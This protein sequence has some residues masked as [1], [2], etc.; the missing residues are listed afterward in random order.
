MKGME[1]QRLSCPPASVDEQP[2]QLAS[3]FQAIHTAP[4]LSVS[5]IILQPEQALSQTIYVKALTIPLFQPIQ[6][7]GLQ[8]SHKL[9]TGQTSINLDS[10]N[11]PLIL[12]PLLH[13]D[14][15]DHIQTG[16]QKQPETIKIVSGFPVLAQNY[17]PCSPLGSPGKCKNAGKY[18][19]KH[20]GRDCLKPSV[21][22]KHVRSHTGERPF[23]C[24]ICGIAFKTQSNL[25]KHRRTQTH[26]NNARLPSESDSS[27]PLGEH[28][29]GR[30]TIGSPHKTKPSDRNCDGTRTV[31]SHSASD[32]T[33]AVTSENESLDT[34]APEI[35]S[36]F[37]VSESQWTTVDNSCHGRV[38]QSVLEKEFMK[39]PATPLQKRKIQEQRCQ[40]AAKP[41][42][43][44]RQ[45]ATY[46]EKLWE[47][48]SPDYKLKKCESTDSGYMSRSDSVEQQ[49]L[50]PNCLHSLCEHS[51]ETESDTTITS[52]R[53]TAGNMAKA[54]STEKSTGG[55][56][57]EKKKLEEHIS[58]LI[59]QNKAVV[60]NTQLD[61]VRPRKTVLSKQGSIDLPMPYTYKDSFHFD[62]RPFDSSRKKL[63]QC[64]AKSIFTPIEKS[65][66][67][68]FHSV[69]T[70]FS[71]TI[72]YVPVSRSNSMPFIESTRRIQDQADIS[73]AP[74]LAKMSHDTSSAL[75]SSK[76]KS[77]SM[78]DFPSSHPRALVRQAAVDDLPPSNTTDPSSSEEVKGT[79]KSGL[80]GEGTSTKHKKPNQRKAKMFTQEKW[81]VYGD[82]TFKK[83]YQKMKSNQTTKKQK[84]N[85]ITDISSFHL[86]TK[87][88]GSHD[89][90]PKDVKGFKTEN[91]VCSSV[92]LSAK[93]N[94]EKLVSSS[95]TVS[96]KQ[97]TEELEGYCITS[98]PSQ[99]GS[100]QSLGNFAVSVCEQSELSKTF[101]ESSCRGLCVSK[102]DS[103]GND[104]VLPFN[105]GC[106]LS[107]QLQQT[108][109]QEENS[110]PLNIASLQDTGLEDACAQGELVKGMLVEEDNSTA[111]DPTGKES[112]YLEQEAFLPKHCNSSEPTQE[113]PKLPSERKKL[114]VDKLKREENVLK[115]THSSSSSVEGNVELTDHYKTVDTVASESIHHLVKEES[116]IAM[117]GLNTSGSSNMGYK[118]SVQCPIMTSEKQDDV[119]DLSDTRSVLSLEQLGTEVKKGNTYDLYALQKLKNK[120]YREASPEFG[121]I[122]QAPTQ[123]LIFDQ[124]NPSLKKNDFLPKYI[125]KYSQGK[126]TG[127]PLILTGEPKNMPCISSAPSILASRSLGSKST[128]VFLCPPTI[129]ETTSITTRP[130][131]KCHLQRVKQKEK[132][133]DMW[134]GPNNRD[135]L[136]AQELAQKS[137]M[138]TIVCTSH[139][140]GKKI[141]FTT[142][143]TGGLFI[144][145][146]ITGQSSALQFV[147]SGNSSVISVSSLV[148]RTVFCGNTDEK[149][150]EWQSD[151]NSFPGFQDLPTCSSAMPR[152]LSHSSNMLYCHMLHAQQKE[153]HTLPQLSSHAR[154]SKGPIKYVSFPNLNAEPQLTWCCLSRNLPLPVEQKEKRDSAYSSLHTC[155]NEKLISKCNRLFYKMKNT[156]KSPAA[157][158]ITGVPQTATSSVSPQQQYFSTTGVDGFFKNIPEQERAK[159]KLHKMRELT[160]HK[161]KK[162]HKR[163]KVKI[164]PKC[165]RGSYRQRHILF[166]ANRPI[167]QHWPTTRV[168]EPPKKP[169]SPH[170]PNSRQ[171]CRRCLCLL[172]AS[173]GIDENP[174]E[175]SEKAGSSVEKNIMKKDIPG[176]TTEHSSG[177][178]SPQKIP[179]VSNEPAAKYSYPLASNAS[180]QKARSQELCSS[181]ILQTEPQPDINFHQGWPS[182][183]PCNLEYINT[184]KA[185]LYN[186]TS[187]HVTSPVLIGSKADSNNI[188]LKSQN[189]T[190]SKLS[191]HVTGGRKQFTDENFHP[192]LKEQPIFQ[193]SYPVPLKSRM[194]LEKSFPDKSLPGP[195][196]MQEASSTSR[197]HRQE[198]CSVKPDDHLE[199]CEPDS[200]GTLSK[201]YKKQSLEMISKE[202]NVSSSD[203]EDRLII[204]I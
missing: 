68:F 95:V 15:T 86:G 147:H 78:A 127:L 106:E 182:S 148:E 13:S 105:T 134:K 53:C 111:Q 89:G 151:I 155:M 2:D 153:V 47:G 4:S 135:N 203:D 70:Q 74:S 152:C 192:P 144:S 1:A 36:L 169:S 159:D 109:D 17:S 90:I 19:C 140:P 115:P 31:I 174:Q 168:L 156:R 35:N 117:G 198:N 121:D 97:N 149:I 41:S 138:H 165:Y 85:K 190:E 180:A 76:E 10:S 92:T 46:T 88:I 80:E 176:T 45:Q 110:S 50:S 172:A 23:P 60:D 61:N 58:K 181:G 186:F 143:Y 33:A 173:Q 154:D 177:S 87:D 3:C 114:K 22:E 163:R 189:F 57:L 101:V 116:Q 125:L 161:A 25:Y 64:T 132:M 103:S 28:E 202:Y 49:M 30:E 160:A 201:A 118:E 83:I 195:M 16:I 37:V 187:S 139:T 9:L 124:I 113:L 136:G 204:E 200:V 162:S 170:I 66:P 137:N 119:A 196:Q 65:K 6:S 7:E 130:N 56:T 179:R 14:G 188:E 5:P 133:K 43:L 197:P 104:E 44:Q 96:A 122:A 171:H 38:N 99:C 39:D 112:F 21:L 107:F 157:G 18:L 98:P 77:A 54:D 24:T 73:K 94:T 55:L 123:H 82:E 72:D 40:T 75:L 185:H 183:G 167:K 142:M 27:S 81:Q 71:T 91:L 84:E 146:D 145:S 51:T 29:K 12:N 26:V 141:C 67:L 63:F 32:S 62:I 93:P 164:A 52:V 175:I 184:S 34:S 129:L 79:K 126:T 150:E 8:P 178:F 102:Q 20:C 166:K 42:Q 194:L 158:S 108:T 193:C 191:V 69:P 131:T 199:V 100:S 11:I 59:S 120:P 48:R 128:D